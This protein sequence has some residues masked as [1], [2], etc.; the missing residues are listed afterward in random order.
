MV[1]TG[2]ARL[3]KWPLVYAMPDLKTS[4]IAKIVVEEV[5]TLFGVPE[6]LLSDRGTTFLSYLMN[7]VCGYLGVDKLN[8]TAHHPQCDG[9][10]GQFNRTLSFSRESML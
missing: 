7:D 4:R 1:C 6:A 9:L 10:T 5:L 3:H 8:T 2:S